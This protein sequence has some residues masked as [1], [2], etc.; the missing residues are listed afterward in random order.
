MK[1]PGKRD[2]DNQVRR[3]SRK[4]LNRDDGERSGDANKNTSQAL[5][6]E[7]SE[8]RPAAK[9]SPDGQPPHTGRTDST[10]NTQ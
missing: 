3:S 4:E 5:G 9:V 6:F 7:L 8:N 1:I 10:T 2:S